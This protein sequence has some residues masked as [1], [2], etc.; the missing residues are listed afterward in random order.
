MFINKISN[1]TV[2]R[3]KGY[4]HET[5]NVGDSTY[6]FYYPYDHT[7]ENCKLQI[8]KLIPTENYNYQL[9]EKP[10]LETSLTPDGVAV[11]INSLMELNRD[12]PFAYRYVKTD[13]NTNS[14]IYS[15][16]DSGV[17][18]SLKEGNKVDFWLGAGDKNNQTYTFVNRNTTTPRI[19]G[20]GYL[21]YPDSQRVG[22]KYKGFNDPD[23]GAIYTD[24]AEQ[25]EMEKVTRTFSNKTGGNLAGLEQNI[26]YLTANGYKIQPSNPIAGGDNK[27]SHHYAN[28][29]N[30]HISKDLGNIENFSS[31]I[32]KLFQNGIVYVHDSTYTS[33]GLEGI[34]FQYALR[35]ADKNPQ[36]YYWFKMQGLKDKPLGL[37]VIPKN[38]EN[39]R[40]RAINPPVIYDEKTKGIVKNINYDPNKE[41]LFQIYDGSMVTDDQ[42]SNLDK[43]I[44]TYKNLKSGNPLAVSSHDDTIVNYVFEI[45][46]QEYAE[47]LNAFVDFNKNNEK[48]VVFNSPEG[49]ELVA[50]FSNFKLIR[51]TDGGFGTWD[52]NTDLVKMN[53]FI[54]AFDEKILESISDPAERE[55]EKNMFIRGAYEAQD[56][57]FQNI[58]YWINV[59][60][61]AQTL[62]TAQ[63]LKGATTVEKVEELIKNKLLPQETL[64]TK[65]AMENVLN[66]YYNL[67]PKGVMDSND[68]TTKAIMSLP[69]E[70]LELAENTL[71]VLATSYFTNR[72]TSE[73]TLGLSRFELLK[74]NNPHLVEPYKKVYEN[75]N[76]IYMDNIKTFA[77]DIIKK[78][79]ETSAEKLLDENGNYTEYGEY[80]IEQMGASITKYAF[81]K[82]FVGD[83]L[84][85]KI[86]PNGEI[87]YDYSDIEAKTSLKSLGINAYNPTDEAEQLQGIIKK[88]IK[89]LNQADID[90]LAQSISKKI[91]G[92]NVNSFR[93]AEAMVNKA[94]LFMGIRIDALKD[95]V[96]QDGG[97]SRDIA[98]ADNWD[99]LIGFW[100]RFVQEVKKETPSA[101]I[102]AEMTD[103]PDVMRDNFG[104]AASCYDNMPNIGLKYSS[105]PEALL[106]FFNETGVTTE[107]GYEYF[108]STV[109]ETFGANF[110]NGS[111]VEDV[112]HRCN[113][114]I[115]NLKKLVNTRSADYIR[116][117]LTFVDNHDKPRMLHC[118]A[119][120]MKLFHGSYNVMNDQDNFDYEKNRKN[121]VDSLIQLANADDYA[122]LPLEAKLNCDNPEYFNT[123]S[124]YAIAMGQL[125]R[126]SIND[127]LKDKV[128]AEEMKYLKLALVDLVNGNYQESGQT[129]QIP[130]INIPE[131]TNTE[132]A[133]KDI[134]K[135]ANMTLTK[136]EFDAIIKRTQDPELVNQ[137]VVQGDFDWGGD[138]AKRNLEMAQTVLKGGY[139]TVS[140]EE[141]NFMKY[142]PYTM[143]VA[144]LLRQAFIDVKGENVGSRYIFLNAVKQYAQHFTRD[145]VESN[146]TK[147]PFKES[148]EAAMAKNK[149]GVS[150]I[151]TA[152]EMVFEQAEFLAKKDGKLGVND[153]FKNSTEN[154][155]N[156]WQNATE[157]AAQKMIM[158]LTLLCSLAGIPVLFAGDELVLSGYDEKT[159]NIYLP[160]NPLRWTETQKGIFK[161]YI[162]RVQK[163]VNET[164]KI[165]SRESVSALNNGTPYVLST[166]D[167]NVPAFMMQDAQGNMTVSVFNYEGVNT[168]AR[169]DYFSELG[170]TDANKEQI[171]KENNI[172]SI[173]ANNRYVPIQKKK[174]IDYIELGL[175]ISLPVGLVFTNSDIRDKAV[176]EVRKILDKAGKETNRLGIFNKNGKIVLDGI[177][178][179]NGAMILSF[180]KKKSK[181]IAFLGNTRKYNI[182]SNPYKTLETPISGEKLSL[183]S[184]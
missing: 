15:G 108:F 56:M 97:R 171:F 44:E 158:A 146:R 51:K 167:N 72:A 90:Y 113:L 135:R 53:Y 183:I 81:L 123:A 77:E 136:E 162:T 180:I 116:N 12:E 11:D 121:R 62:Y 32:K 41:T 150:D 14:I 149:F 73:E 76:I 49:T 154:V 165:R 103:V 99:R 87:T 3:F 68:I 101:L 112:G 10:I 138:I 148:R 86:L 124:S 66:G 170:I 35:W 179:K 115:N 107:A 119:L 40:H 182:V 74:E 177:T 65:D 23:T 128:S 58:K 94:S 19:Q 132:L 63:V 5:N 24:E 67:K 33:E 118:F 55:Y 50:Q 6:H 48:P 125:I 147:L 130:S 64:L 36:T 155:L 60:K 156:I 141:T 91:E 26:E 59:S 176:Y 30:Y 79:N 120:D 29:N 69:L 70:S 106:K 144:G 151:R 131:L 173:N 7:T 168:N 172:E 169:H 22:I 166:N 27:F 143:G 38:K 47:R 140:A 92:T 134:L 4:Q 61:N 142:S 98:F 34:H 1:V 163:N 20:S 37:G 105:T 43:P 2:P 102:Q 139:E 164:M 54:S 122:S 159:K 137:F 16:A 104:D 80:V 45:K 9:V 109:M 84:K 96:D 85:T 93:L 160:R 184:K 21:V 175:G 82:A 133:L 117:L 114:I 161:D 39:L 17:T 83:S 127:T 18:F 52:A 78:V 153:H 178:A 75:M 13:K 71:G 145:V 8:F 181:N 42:I 25:A 95:V 88:G 46:P 100:K 28:K 110:E 129:T 111:T 157:P 174:E 126:N 57:V 31:Y 89:N 152:I